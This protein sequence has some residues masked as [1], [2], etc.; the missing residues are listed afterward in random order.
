MTALL[1]VRD[2]AVAYANGAV[3]AV[4]GA[5][6]TL[7]RGG[8]L[9][10]VGES[11]CGKTTL[12]RAL[13]GVLP[14]GARITRGEAWLDGTDLVALSPAARRAR[15]WRELAFVPQ[16]AMSALDPVYRLRDQMREV[17]CDRGGLSRAAADA[18]AVELFEAVGLPP[19]RLMDYPHQFSGG[20]RQRAA[21]A[22]ALALRPK[23]VIADEPV[24]AL[25]VIVQRQVLDTFR[26]LSDELGLSAIIVT[27]DISVVA[28]LCSQVAVMYAG[29]VVE[30][31]PTEAVL[32][33]PS[34][35]YTMGLMNAFPDLES[36]EAVLAPIEGA[37]PPLAAP[38][39]G[40]RFAPR[41][42][43]AEAVCA[44]VSP[45]PVALGPDHW[46][47]CHRVPEAAAL[48]TRARDPA[49]WRGVVERVA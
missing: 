4:D 40:C 47:A 5:D 36:D 31:G 49:T 43:F 19:R 18:R 26:S 21:I 46:A 33:Q 29:K 16:T 39:P 1:T 34:H 20:M 22:M 23:L 3:Q 25:D 38:P 37:P 10:L 15:L 2:L 24:T 13:M 41:C 12:A 11:G 17:L 7:P 28:Y 30:H 44:T 45:D 14:G 9:G 8:M 32:E 27:H 6:L 42:P 48:R 35:P